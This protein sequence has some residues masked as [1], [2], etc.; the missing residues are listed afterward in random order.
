ML[1]VAFLDNSLI[2]GIVS[3]TNRDVQIKLWVRERGKKELQR[4]IERI[5]EMI[6][7]ISFV[8]ERR[9]RREEKRREWMWWCSGEVD[10]KW[11]IYIVVHKCIKPR[12]SNREKFDHRDGAFFF[13]IVILYITR[14]R[15]LIRAFSTAPSDNTHLM[16][17][18]GYYIHRFPLMPPFSSVVHFLI[19]RCSP[20]TQKLAW[21]YS[22]FFL[23]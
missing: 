14:Q 10:S 1:H 23:I 17:E 7:W 5:W 19:E 13:C 15:T 12:Q 4:I 21:G 9:R 16:I 6:G 11:E 22:F 18:F 20:P 8:G 3:S 2:F